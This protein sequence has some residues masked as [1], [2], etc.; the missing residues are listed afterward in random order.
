MNA[1]NVREKRNNLRTANA[2]AMCICIL[3]LIFYGG[4]MIMYRNR[5]DYKFMVALTT[6][7]A[8][9]S[10]VGFIMIIISMVQTDIKNEQLITSKL[11][12]AVDFF[13]VAIVSLGL[14]SVL[15]FWVLRA[16]RK[17]MIRNSGQVLYIPGVRSETLGSAL[18]ICL[19]LAYYISRFKGFKIQRS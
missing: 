3:I 11:Q 10:F 9:V 6:P 8:I 16:V 4:Y 19:G 2:L 15:L 12:V 18:M 5:P 7:I 17:E 14:F 1:V 13:S